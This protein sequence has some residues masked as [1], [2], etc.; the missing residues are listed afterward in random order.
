MD[1]TWRGEERKQKEHWD[2]KK[3]FEG[4]R[5]KCCTIVSEQQQYPLTFL[6]LFFDQVLSMKV[7][8]NLSVPASAQWKEKLQLN[9]DLLA[10]NL[11]WLIGFCLHLWFSL[12]SKSLWYWQLLQ[13]TRS[14]SSVR[15]DFYHTTYTIQQ[16]SDISDLWNDRLAKQLQKIVIDP[17]LIRW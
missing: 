12:S 8:L 13:F 3:Y 2:E 9:L 7:T 1:G 6:E 11:L 5:S 4:K 14:I 15:I 16:L 17:S 10:S